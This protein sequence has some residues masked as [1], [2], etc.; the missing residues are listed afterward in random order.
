MEIFVLYNKNTGLIKSSGRIDR[1]R[2]NANRDGSTMLEYVERKLSDPDL[3]VIYFP[4]RNLPDTEKH[5][6]IDEKIV[7]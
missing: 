7:N 4:E 2:D 3:A 1:E 5:K 6:I